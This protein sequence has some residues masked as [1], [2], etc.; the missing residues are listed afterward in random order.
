MKI[1]FSKAL[2][3]ILAMGASSI[4]SSPA[5]SGNSRC[6]LH[7]VLVAAK[8]REEK[9]SITDMIRLN[10][11]ADV[12]E[13]CERVMTSYCNYNVQMK[14]YSPIKLNGSFKPDT[15]GRD[16]FKYSFSSECKIQ[17]D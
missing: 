5:N 16:E 11:E 17:A 3:T 7:G 8:D 10:F 15:D 6:F 13:K 14:G 2:I 9:K 12:K 1:N 4:F